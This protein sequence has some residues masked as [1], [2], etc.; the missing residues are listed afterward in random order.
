MTKR[1]EFGI[2]DSWV[3]ID[4]ETASIRGTP[5]SVGLVEVDGDLIVDRHAWLIRPPVFEFWGFNVALHG[6]TPKMCE[7]APSWEDSLAKILDIAAGRPLVAHNASFDVGVIRDACDLVEIEWPYLRYACTLAIGRRVWPGLSTYSLPF[8]AAHLNVVAESHHDAED[9][10]VVAARIALAALSETRTSTLDELAQRAGIVVGIVEPNSWR[11]CHAEYG[12]SAIPDEPTLGTV[13][14]PAHPLFGKTVVFTGE[15]AIVRREAQQAV[16][17]RG[18]VAGS[19]VNRHTNYLVTGYQ[20]L[21]RLAQNS[22]KSNKLLK[23]DELRA[24]GF[25]IEIITEA[26]F[27]RLLDAFDSD[28]SGGLR[29]KGAG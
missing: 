18:A 9:D 13:V 19:G 26:D 24:E 11:G 10:A 22:D 28:P 3:A 6:I 29:R 25:P 17:N 1:S 27:V 20:D 8:L 5:C 21:T 15:L 12:T 7:H 16:V 4:F 23:A 2:A 14:N